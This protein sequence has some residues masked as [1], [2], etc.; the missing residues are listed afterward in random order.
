[1]YLVGNCMVDTLVKHVAAS[2]ERTPWT[3][4]GFE[5]GG[6]AL[7]TLHRPSN[8]DSSAALK[9]LM[10]SIRAVSERIP[11]LFPVHPRTRTRLE[12]SGLELGTRMRLC[13]P[14]PYMTFLGLMAK[15]RLVLTD[16][17]GIQEET[18]A[19]RVPCLTLR[20]NTERPVTLTRG[21][22][23]LATSPEDIRQGVAD[24]M[25]GRWPEGENIPLWDGRA[26]ERI[27]AILLDGHR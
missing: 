16:S 11:V 19:L 25:E 18:T 17:G 3:A 27:V 13:D 12:E 9:P 1:M 20:R 7:L 21:T 14:L 26:S 23:R 24:V 8:V 22:N 4:M 10:E 5:P 6:Y 2:V 15:A